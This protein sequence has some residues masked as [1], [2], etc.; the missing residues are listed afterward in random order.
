MKRPIKLALWAVFALYLG[1]LLRITVFRGD[2]GTHPLFTDGEIIWIPFVGLYE[3]LCSSIP[4]FLYLFVGN[5]IWFVPFGFLWP[6]LTGCKKWTILLVFLLSLVIETAQFVFGT[7]YSEVEDL[8]LNTIG[9]GIGYGTYLLVENH[10][11]H[12]DS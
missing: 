3:T 11:R 8:I 9:G 12:M 4:Y 10:L 5:L 7:G 2:F 1:V 6:L